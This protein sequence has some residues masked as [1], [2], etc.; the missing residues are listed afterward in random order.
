MCHQTVGL[1]ALH[2][3][4]IGVSTVVVGSARDIIE[5]LGVPRFLFTDLPLGNPIGPPDPTDAQAMVVRD[6][7][8]LATTATRPQT[9]VRSTIVWPGDDG[10]RRSYMAIDDPDALA[11]RGAERR[12]QQANASNRQSP[13]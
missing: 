11:R 1:T 8:E 9:T 6:A 10:W 7:L 13:S 12:A 5:E 3:E 4:S 2:L